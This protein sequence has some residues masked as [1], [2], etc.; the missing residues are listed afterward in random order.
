MPTPLKLVRYEQAFEALT[1]MA[2]EVKSEKALQA[3]LASLPQTLIQLGYLQ[4]VAILSNRQHAEKVVLQALIDY[5]GAVEPG[6]AN[7]QLRQVTT[8]AVRFAHSM[9]VLSKRP[10]TGTTDKP[11]EP[12]TLT[13]QELGGIDTR[14]SDLLRLARSHQHKI[15][16]GLRFDKFFNAYETIPKHTGWRS[17]WVN[18]F[19]GRDVG[20]QSAMDAAHADLSLV[21]EKCLGGN[22]IQLKTTAPLAIGL[23]YENAIENGM[24]WH[25]SLGVPYLPA[26]SVKGLLRA[27]MTEWTDDATD[28]GASVVNE[29]FGTNKQVG[30]L[31]VF[32]A[33]PNRVVRLEADVTTPHWGTW[34][35]KP[36]EKVDSKA[37]ANFPT[38]WIDP[39]PVHWL[40]V[41]NGT[42][43]TFYLALKDA[44]V[45]KKAV[46]VEHLRNALLYLGAGAKTATGYGRF[47]P[48]KA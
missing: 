34:G 26:S 37:G 6:A 7:A 28:S 36:D 41:P 24:L 14:H 46:L 16:Q 11:E 33:L 22:A 21:A 40:R 17:N 23:G 9:K 4:T 5:L 20:D 2:A 48:S 3:A 42:P 1:S 38:D 44:D 12:K 47:G 31:T 8:R 45:E 25:H 32:D 30:K 27:W 19:A 43:F 15:H 10:L 35:E 39:K 13:A 18:Q 29:W